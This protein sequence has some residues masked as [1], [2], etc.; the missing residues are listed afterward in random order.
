MFE[1][2]GDDEEKSAIA[3]KSIKKYVSLWGIMDC[4][5]TLF[6]SGSE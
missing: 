5:F 1:E 4:Q 2:K 3:Y 6:F